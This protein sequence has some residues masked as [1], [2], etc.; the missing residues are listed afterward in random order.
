MSWWDEKAADLQR[1]VRKGELEPQDY[2]EEQARQAAVHAR[3]DLVLVS[4]LLSSANHLLASIRFTLIVLT[5]VVI[6]AIA[7]KVAHYW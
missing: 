1:S 6:V 5:L 2:T 7:L 4:S 3:E